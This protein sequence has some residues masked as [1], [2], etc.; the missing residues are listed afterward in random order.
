MEHSQSLESIRSSGGQEIPH[1]LWNPKTHYRFQNQPR[2]R[3][4]KQVNP[5]QAFPS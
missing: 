2:Y 5:V 1:I 4:L 3:I